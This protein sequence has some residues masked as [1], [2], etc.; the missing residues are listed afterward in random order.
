MHLSY[1]FRS[2]TKLI[3]SFHLQSFQFHVSAKSHRSHSGF[4]ES[5]VGFCRT[6]GFFFRV[7]LL[8]KFECV[9]QYTLSYSLKRRCFKDIILLG[10]RLILFSETFVPRNALNFA[11]CL[12]EKSSFGM[13][14]VSSVLRRASGLVSRNA[15]DRMAFGGS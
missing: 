8:Q 9:L 15:W 10:L 5:G 14:V 12:L 2:P 3:K 1:T 11:A 6:L 4:N 7:M 13:T